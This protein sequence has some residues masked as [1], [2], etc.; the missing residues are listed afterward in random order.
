[1]FGVMGPAIEEVFVAGGSAD[2]IITSTPTVST[3]STSATFTFTISAGSAEASVDG[4]AYAPATSPINLVGLALGAHTIDIRSI[5]TP[6]VHQSFAWTVSS[7]IVGTP[8]VL[9]NLT[10]AAGTPVSPS[11]PLQFDIVDADGFALIIPMV[12][13]DDF[14]VPEP[15]ARGVL[16]ADFAFEPRYAS[17]TRIAIVGGFRY[18]I[19]RTGGWTAS[20]RLR[21]WAVDAFGAVWIGP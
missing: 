20:P 6:A 9:S 15:V 18:T 11:T 10:P 5:T 17:S 16:D 3:T 13:L 7:G 4:G 21:T 14:S 8:P 1:M 12:Q 19:R 2:V